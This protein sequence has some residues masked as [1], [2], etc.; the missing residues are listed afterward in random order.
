MASP[1]KFLIH[2]CPYFAVLCPHLILCDAFCCLYTI[3]FHF[4]HSKWKRKKCHEWVKK[5]QKCMCMANVSLFLSQPE[6]N[7]TPQLKASITDEPTVQVLRL[8]ANQWRLHGAKHWPS[9]N[10]TYGDT[11]LYTILTFTK[12]ESMQFFFLKPQLTCTWSK[13]LTLKWPQKLHPDL[14]LWSLV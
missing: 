4:N 11:G 5:P 7:Y 6:M 14:Q 12:D 3:S 10:W 8:R 13:I 9:T 1:P 2:T